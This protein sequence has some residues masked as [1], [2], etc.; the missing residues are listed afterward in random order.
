MF[1]AL[2]NTRPSHLL[3]PALFDFAALTRENLK[4]AENSTAQDAGS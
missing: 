1:R 3:D 4:L 2:M